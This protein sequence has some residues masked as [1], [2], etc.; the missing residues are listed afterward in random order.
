MAGSRAK[1]WN[2]RGCGT[3][4]IAAALSS[5]APAAAWPQSAREAVAYPTKPIRFV[6]PSS[7]GGGI[8][9]LARLFGP[10]MSESWGRPVIVDNRPGAGGII[11]YDIVAKAPADGHTLLMAAGGYSLNSILYA[12]LPFDTLKDFERVSLLACAPNVLVVHASVPVKTVNELIALAKAK[13]RQL[14]YASAGVGTTS[15]LSA[16]LLV[17]LSG[18]ELVHV[19]YKGAGESAAAIAAGQVQLTFINPNAA[20]SHAKAGRVRALGVTSARRLAMIADI[21]TVAENGLP[22]FEVNN[23]F[24]VLAPGKTPRPIIDKLNA[25]LLRILQLADIRAQLTNLGYDI[26]GGTP[27]EYTAFVRQDI[28]KWSQA[29]AGAGIVPQ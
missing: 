22:G 20:M 19:P 9:V 29:L 28:A 24:G 27:E 2:S 11:G 25:E 21:P 13:P 18:M 26:V 15:H 4:A 8:D 1:L 23:C 14:N 6:A 12:K 16:L 3:V 17:H 5:L 7:A 10:R